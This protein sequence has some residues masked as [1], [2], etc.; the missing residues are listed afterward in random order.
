[1][2]LFLFPILKTQSQGCD[3]HESRGFSL[4]PSPSALPAFPS[5]GMRRGWRFKALSHWRHLRIFTPVDTETRT[6]F[7]ASSPSLANLAFYFMFF[8]PTGPSSVN[9][10]VS[11]RKEGD[12]LSCGRS[13]LFLNNTS[14]LLSPLNLENLLS[15]RIRWGQGRE[16]L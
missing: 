3:A 10:R 2:L 12:A 1:M 13:S 16:V 4:I 5:K 11:G 8:N 15:A 7:L 14:S 6:T 9:S